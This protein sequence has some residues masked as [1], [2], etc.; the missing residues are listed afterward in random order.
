MRGFYW[1]RGRVRCGYCSSHGHNITTCKLVDWHANEALKK[2]EADP[3]Y[4]CD[5]H[6]HRALIEIK[7]REERKQK[8]RK[9]RSKS[10]CS[11][12]KSESHKRPA[13]KLL[14]DYRQ[15]VY[16]ANKNWKRAFTSRVNEVGIGV[17]SL[18]KIDTKTAS[19]L[20]LNVD[21]HKIAMI[22]KFDLANLNLFCGLDNWSRFQSDS[23]VHFMS[24]DRVDYVSIKYFSNLLGQEILSTSW[25]FPLTQIPEVLTPMKW[26]PEKEWLESEWDEVFD[27]YF[28]KIKA[29]GDRENNS[30]IELVEKWANYF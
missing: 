8:T 13:C 30:A 21:G 9:P 2:I 15:K 3:S 26:E 10:K 11:Y 20:N 4:V 24:G 29:S 12:C 1:G 25:W 27:W 22:T 19:D 18:I 5:R 17:G 7:N 16:R 14:K 6:E 23:Q 28:S